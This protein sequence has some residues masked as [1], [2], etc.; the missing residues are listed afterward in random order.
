MATARTRAGFNHREPCQTR[1]NCCGQRWLLRE[2]AHPLGHPQNSARQGRDSWRRRLRR[3]FSRGGAA[4]GVGA[5]RLPRTALAA[6]RRRRRKNPAAGNAG[7][8]ARIAVAERRRRFRRPARGHETAP[9]RL[10]EVQEGHKKTTEDTEDAEGGKVSARGTRN[11]VLPG[12]CGAPPRAATI[13][14]HVILRRAKPGR[15]I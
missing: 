13:P 4:G 11:S 7:R 9:L 8:G 1:E 6:R 12:R 5:A 10:A 14:D 15:R 3:R 2:R